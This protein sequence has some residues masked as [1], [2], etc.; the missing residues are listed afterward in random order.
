MLS[1]F[2][3]RAFET[4]RAGVAKPEGR[5]G[6]VRAW[7][8]PARGIRLLDGRQPDGHLR[9]ARQAAIVRGVECAISGTSTYS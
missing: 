2:V 8:P 7:W 3:S 5:R 9:Y 4:V 6:V 1:A